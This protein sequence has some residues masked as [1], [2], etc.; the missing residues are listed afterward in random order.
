MNCFRLGDNVGATEDPVLNN[1]RD[2]VTIGF[3]RLEDRV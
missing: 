1:E 2:K 3:A